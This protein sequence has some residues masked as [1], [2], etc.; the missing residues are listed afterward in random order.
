MKLW[1]IR[2][3]LSDIKYLTLF[4]KRYRIPQGKGAQYWRDNGFK[5]GCMMKKI[6]GSVYRWRV[7]E[8][9]DGHKELAYLRVLC[10]GVFSGGF[11]AIYRGRIIPHLLTRGT[12]SRIKKIRIAF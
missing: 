10:N 3:F 1:E 8:Y 7:I 5:Y 12:F 6:D 2:N 9:D 4:P 11:P